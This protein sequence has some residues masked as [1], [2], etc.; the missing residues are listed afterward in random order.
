[1]CEEATQTKLM[2]ILLALC[3]S[4]LC[5]L[6]VNAQKSD[7]TRTHYRIIRGGFIEHSTE[8]KSKRG[9][10]NGEAEITGGRKVV[11][12]G[13][14]KDGEKVGRWRFFKAG[15]TLEQ[16]YNYSTK[17]LEYNLPLQNISVEIDSLKDGDKVIAPAKIGGTCF[18]L[19]YLLNKYQ[20]PNEIQKNTGEY[21]LL[22]IFHLNSE[23]KL[24][25]YQTRYVNSNLDR[26]YEIDLKKLNP[27]DLEFSAAKVNGTNVNSIFIY[28]VKF[29]VHSGGY[30]RLY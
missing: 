13:L 29:N 8:L 9:L 17:K 6:T 30:P 14:Y 26:S 28:K 2:K 5:C 15:D 19:V 27:E 18:G 10:K 20:V 25:K 23:G 1:M 24:T 12:K 22:F 4:I 21:E 16:V 3:I 11:A 7:S